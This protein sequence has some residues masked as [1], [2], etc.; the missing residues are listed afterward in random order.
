MPFRD[1][2]KVVLL[3]NKRGEV[4]VY[5]RQINRQVVLR[6]QTTDLRCLEKVF[7]ADEYRSPFAISPNL[8]IDAGA[9]V[10]MATLYFAYRYPDAH[11][12]AIEPEAQNFEILKRNC[13]GL[14]N[15][16]L[17]KAA[18]WPEVCKLGIA[19]RGTEKWT[20]YVTAQCEEVGGTVPGVT[21]EQI[22]QGL[23]ADRIDL[24]KL[25]VEGSE[26]ELFS[27]GAANWLD[28]VGVIVIELHDR[29]LPGCARAFYS[30]L[31]SRKFIQE[32]RGENIFVQQQA[33]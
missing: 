6:R 20:F 17:M 8:I 19:N 7:I 5:L 27:N 32:V 11:V 4:R 33:A 21:I 23:R 30:A 24:L 22:L 12:V 9:N 31:I 13:E 29:Y 15:V 28:R 16:T 25:D 10:G 1:A 26:L 3:Q 14:A 18:L 2:M